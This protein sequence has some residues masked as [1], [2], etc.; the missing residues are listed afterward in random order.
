MAFRRRIYS[1]HMHSAHTGF[2]S[3]VDDEPEESF[4][5]AQD[6]G[7]QASSAAGSQATQIVRLQPPTG[8]SSGINH[9]CEKV[10]DHYPTRAHVTQGDKGLEY[11]QGSIV[12][13]SLVSKKAADLTAEQLLLYLTKCKENALAAVHE[14]ATSGVH[15][16]IRKSLGQGGQCVVRTYHTEHLL[17]V[18]CCW[19][20]CRK[21]IIS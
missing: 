10:E 15:L 5:S 7:A 14:A 2:Y 16:H 20:C 9:D 21:H 11:R 3:A 13:V 12:H 4:Y 8:S 17:A 18:A 1:Q 19:C 6:T